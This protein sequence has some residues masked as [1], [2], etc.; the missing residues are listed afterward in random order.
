MTALVQAQAENAVARLE[1]SIKHDMIRRRAAVGLD[2]GIPS[3]KSL[4]GPFDGH[5]LDPVDDFASPMVTVAHEAFRG[6]VLYD[7][8][9]GRPHGGGTAVFGGNELQGVL[10]APSLF[11]DQVVNDGIVGVKRWNQEARL[12]NPAERGKAA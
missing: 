12:E 10:L 9:Q 7:G 2:V 11:L 1:N 3:P 6:L 8:S 4:Q 5:C